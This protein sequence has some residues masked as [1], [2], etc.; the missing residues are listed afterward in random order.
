MVCGLWFVVLVVLFVFRLFCCSSRYGTVLVRLLPT[1]YT[2]HIRMAEADAP[3]PPPPAPTV[4]PTKQ[5]AEAEKK[6]G[7]ELFATK[8]Y[9]EAIKHYNEA[10]RLDPDNA[11]FYSNRSACHASMQNW[12][13]ALEDALQC[14]A[15]DGNFIKGYFRLAIAQAELG[16]FD[17]AETTCRAALSKEPENE[18]AVKQLKSVR[19]KRAAA[20]QKKKGPAKQLDEAQ[21][22]EYMELQEQ[23]GSYTRDLRS[24]VGRM[25]AAQRESRSN[26]IT[27]SHIDGYADDVPLYRTVG[28]AFVLTP[29]TAIASRLEEELAT[30][31]KNQRD[32]LDR[33]EYLERRITSSQQGIRDITGASQ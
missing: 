10:I 17:D 22:K 7:N 2:L 25:N 19:A 15:K 9:E 1:P 5:A 16:Y 32:L 8:K 33:K 28:K 14:V 30:L 18:H 23:I 20:Q 13:Q 4:D 11:V 21:I 12:Q 6:L 26:Q 31:T 3:P 24:V 27:R 29:K